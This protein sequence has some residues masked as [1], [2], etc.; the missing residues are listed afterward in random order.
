MKGLTYRGPEH[1]EVVDVAD[2]EPP[3]E[4][5][6]VVAV[7]TA[8]ICGSDLHIYDGHG[9]SSELGFCLGHEAV[10]TIAALGDRVTGMAVGDRVL[11]S[12]AVGCSTCRYCRAG[13]VSR[14]LNA[15]DIPTVACYGLSPALPGSQAQAVAVPH[16][17]TN[18]I[19]IPDSLSDADA[20][21]LSDNA[22][23]AWYG[24]RRARIE[25]GDT[26]A[27]IGLGPVG[28]MS[29]QSAFAMGAS[30]VLAVDLVRDR[31]DA[32]AAMGAEPVSAT[33]TKAAIRAA[34]GGG[35][36]AVI[37]AVGADQTIALAIKIAR[38]GGRVSVIGVNQNRAFGVDLLTAQLNEL[39]FAIGLCSVQY[40]LPT[41]FALVEGGRL[42]PSEVVTHRMPLSDGAEAYRL[43]AAREGGVGKILLDPSA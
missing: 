17:V 27:V 39:E 35:V 30:R 6:A 2:P 29:V 22:P 14:C 25:P 41:L 5:G 28:L 12:A 33:D 43:F 37:E 13:L 4:F 23:T 42:R 19:P 7:S 34:T 3:D 38:R 26:V 36:D 20:V 1:V 40:E 21:V 32:A 31:L 16:A 8:G 10:G 15:P 11:V 9:F 24:A 18:L